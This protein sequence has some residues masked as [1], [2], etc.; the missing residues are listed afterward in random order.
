MKLLYLNILCTLNSSMTFE[1]WYVGELI[2][3]LPR[4]IAKPSIH[5]TVVYASALLWMVTSVFFMI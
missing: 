1:D 2:P 5:I 4:T 3:D